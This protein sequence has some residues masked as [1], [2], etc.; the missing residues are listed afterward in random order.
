M[1]FVYYKSF[2]PSPPTYIQ[3][4]THTHIYRCVILCY[5]VPRAA[6]PL[7]GRVSGGGF[8][9]IITPRNP[10]RIPARQWSFIGAPPPGRFP[11]GRRGRLNSRRER[12]HAC[13]AAPV[14]AP[15]AAAT[16]HPPPAIHRQ[17]FHVTRDR[18]SSLRD[19]STL[20]CASLFR[21]RR[22]SDALSLLPTPQRWGI[23]RA[24]VRLGYS[25][26]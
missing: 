6:Q 7:R 21:R 8:I 25:L 10:E 24:R 2:V 1:Q 3:T 26:L 22:R 4:H 18:S 15:A 9:T 13:A 20:H 17:S 12:W 14:Q 5:R 11:I 16:R 19:R 23:V